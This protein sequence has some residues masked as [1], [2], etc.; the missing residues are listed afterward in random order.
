MDHDR[1]TRM[2]IR[3]LLLTCLSLLFLLGAT[4]PAR[5]QLQ[6]PFI[7]E[8]SKPGGKQTVTLMGS[9]HIGRAD[10]YPLPEV[11]Q[12]RFDAA[13]VLAVEAD[14]LLPETQQIC[15]RLARTD[16]PLDQQLPAEDFAA[17][18]AYVRASN[19]PQRVIEG[20]KLWMINL[21]L[22]AIEIAQLGIDFS[23]GIDIALLSAA[24]NTGKRIVEIEGAT[25]QCTSLSQASDAEAVAG[26]QRF[27]ATIREN[28]MEKRLHALMEH[29]RQGDGPKLLEVIDEEFGTS[30]SGRRARTRLFD[31][32]HPHMA[33]VINGYLDRSEPHFVVIGVGHML[34]ANNLLDALAKRGIKAERIKP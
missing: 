7:W 1:P 5:A 2:P 21:V 23:R 17:L 6:A 25:R 9:L 26:F 31:E 29:Y 28:R 20:K 22:T 30:A 11:V 16:V 27:L 10:F 24:R 19:I 32:R 34:G 8:L 18:Q 33:D 14:V 12:K 4:L 3:P 15:D 13:R